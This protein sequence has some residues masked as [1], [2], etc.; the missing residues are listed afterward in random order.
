MPDIWTAPR[1]WTTGEVVTSTLMN[2]HLR[3]NL[4]H[5][6]A[7]VDA[8]MPAASALSAASYSTSS[9]SFLDMDSSGLSLSLTT[10]GGPVLLGFSGSVSASTG[11]VDCYFDLL[12]DGVRMGGTSTGSAHLTTG[13]AGEHSALHFI[14]LRGLAAGAHTIRL[15]W[16]VGG[17]TATFG[18]VPV[19]LFAVELR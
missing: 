12:I 1:T 2:T 15:Q 14:G 18:S 9:T 7:R 3:D 5:L 13:T 11:G 16:R 6:K 19:G 17:G 8:P 4:E 10:S